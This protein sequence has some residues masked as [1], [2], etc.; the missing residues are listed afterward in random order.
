M[1]SVGA[2]RPSQL[3][4]AFGVGSTIDLPNFSVVVSGLDSW[5]D[6]SQEVLTEPRLLDAVRG[7]LGAQ[8]TELRS[9]LAR[10]GFRRTM[11]EMT[12]EV[13]SA[14]AGPEPGDG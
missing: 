5:D 10:L 14:G 9:S 3:M 4:Y 7:Q 6:R 13:T 2:V 11:V 8:V 12:R 1:L